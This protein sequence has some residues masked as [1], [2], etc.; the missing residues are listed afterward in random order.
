MQ[1][2]GDEPD[3]DDLAAFRGV[4]QPEP[5]TVASGLIVEGDL[6][7][8]GQRVANVRRIVDRQ[9]SPAMRIDIGER[10]IREIGPFLRIEASHTANVTQRGSGVAIDQL[11][12]EAGELHLDLDRTLHLQ[13][14]TP[15]GELLGDHERGRRRHLDPGSAVVRSAE[16]PEV[17]PEVAAEHAHQ[18]RIDQHRRRHP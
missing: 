10:P 12:A 7:E 15:A 18:C 5:C 16:L 14:G 4:E 13:A 9:P 17:P 8:A 6:A 2:A 1:L 3:G 11:L